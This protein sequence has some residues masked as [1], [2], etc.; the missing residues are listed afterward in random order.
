MVCVQVFID[1]WNLYDFGSHL[2]LLG[3]SD[4]MLSH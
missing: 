4:E 1:Q 2:L 3:I